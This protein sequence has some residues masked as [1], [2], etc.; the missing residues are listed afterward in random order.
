MEK[1]WG[2]AAL[3]KNDRNVCTGRRTPTFGTGSCA[4][5]SGVCANDGVT[6]GMAAPFLALVDLPVRDRAGVVA[7]RLSPILPSPLY[8]DDYSAFKMGQ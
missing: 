8:W 7:F 2:K 5:R 4:E 6:L 1:A 3:R